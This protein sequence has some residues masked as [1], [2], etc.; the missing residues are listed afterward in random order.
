M[1]PLERNAIINLLENALDKMALEHYESA[2]VLINRALYWVNGPEDSD[3]LDEEGG[4]DELDFNGN[5]ER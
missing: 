5:P 4:W 2:E 3:Y 1:T